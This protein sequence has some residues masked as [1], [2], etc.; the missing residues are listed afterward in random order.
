MW[1]I[2]DLKYSAFKHGLTLQRGGIHEYRKQCFYFPF[3]IDFYHRRHTKDQHLTTI[4][5]RIENIVRTTR[6]KL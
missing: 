4:D 1:E 6:T 5:Q 3:K 2:K